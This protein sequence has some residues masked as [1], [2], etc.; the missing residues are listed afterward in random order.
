[1]NKN[2]KITA[3]LVGLIAISIIAAYSTYGALST[4][5]T[6]AS[7]GNV[8]V[9]P[10]LAVYQDS[11]CTTPLTSIDWGTAT[12]GSAI[13]QTVYVK[14]T[15]QDASLALNMTTSNWTPTSANGPIAITWSL[16][17]TRLYP[18]QS[19]A[20]T[21]TAT[22]SSTIADVSNFNV[23]IVITGTQ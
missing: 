16:E 23:Q 21:L 22:V 8:K 13:T 15:G 1:M 17:G 10:G 7:T 14:N 6:L 3:A 19:A 9:S 12:P 18:G 11:A 4:N 5:Q 20:A 2:M